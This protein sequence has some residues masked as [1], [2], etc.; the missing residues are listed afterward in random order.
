[1]D[2]VGIENHISAN[3]SRRIRTFPTI[4][5]LLLDKLEE[6][7]R[8]EP[9]VADDPHW[10]TNW[11]VRVERR[12]NIDSPSEADAWI[13]L[14]HAM[15]AGSN[16]IGAPLFLRLMALGV[17]VRGEWCVAAALHST[18]ITG[19]SVVEDLVQLVVDLGVVDDARA[20]L[21]TVRT[22]PSAMVPWIQ[23]DLATCRNWADLVESRF[24]V[25]D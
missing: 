15:L 6:Q 20:A 3:C 21:G 5:G 17:P 12:M 22:R 18:S 16:D 23:M 10:L 9:G 11:F 14:A 25:R 8:D 1:M 2:R 4:F 7:L 24:P 13:M 19:C